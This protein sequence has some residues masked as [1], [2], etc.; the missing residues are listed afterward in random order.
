VHGVAK[1]LSASKLQQ[2]LVSYFLSFFVLLFVC[3]LDMVGGVEE[4]E[5]RT[6]SCNLCNYFSIPVSRAIN[7]VR[8]WQEGITPKLMLDFINNA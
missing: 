8:F 1:L 4:T 5:C 2:N 3:E 7:V 6:F